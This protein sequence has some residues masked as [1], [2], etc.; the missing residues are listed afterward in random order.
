MSLAS[1]IQA[2][3]KS[4]PYELYFEELDETVFLYPLTVEQQSKY[5][6]LKTPIKRKA[7]LLTSVITSI[8]H[9]YIAANEKEALALPEN[10]VVLC[11]TV[12]NM[13]TQGC[14]RN[15]VDKL[16]DNYISSLNPDFEPHVI[17]ED[18][19]SPNL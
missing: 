16:V 19:Q 9:E 14:K 6:Q 8:D 11:E 7:Y 3:L 15:V 4:N 1:R 13:L 5:L 17:A 2:K 18:E 12:I 10:M